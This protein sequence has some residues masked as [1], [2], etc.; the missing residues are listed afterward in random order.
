VNRIV[1]FAALGVGAYLLI[2]IA[3][4][5]ATRISG[6][7]EERVADLYL[8]GVSGT[9]F[10]GQ[11]AQVVYQGLDLG[12]VHWQFHPL[13]LL[14]G[15][16]EYSLELDNPAN[17]GHLNAG[18]TLTGRVY[19]D[20]LDIEFQPGRLVNHY[21]PTEFNSSGTMQLVFE[22]ISLED[23]YA[24][25]V[26]GRVQWRDAVVLEPVSLVLGQLD[27]DV[28]SE[29]GMLIGRFDNSGDLGV[30][31]EVALSAANEYRVELLLRPG[32]AV[33]RDTL[34]YLEEN[35]QRQANGDYRL[36]LSGQF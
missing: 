1:R 19:I 12:T 27:M 23:D 25:E 11:A 4:F 31:G 18:K 24:G 7:L 8:N 34:G 10:S 3:S 9:V 33:D 20:D 13:A 28:S 26:S 17:A 35:T 14:L 29:D 2:L 22:T 6:E 16:L 32:P 5:P 21:S 30:S 15:R 36:D